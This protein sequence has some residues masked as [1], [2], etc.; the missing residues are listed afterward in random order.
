ML[1]KM[2]DAADLPICPSLGIRT[3]RSFLPYLPCTQGR[4]QPN[5]P[6]PAPFVH[7]TILGLKIQY[8]ATVLQS[9]GPRSATACTRAHAVLKLPTQCHLHVPSSLISTTSAPHHVSM[10]ATS[11]SPSSL[12]STTSAPHHLHDHSDSHRVISVFT[13]IKNLQTWAVH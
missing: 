10:Y 3:A 1:A 4:I 7:C 12:I 13:I 6:P 2:L 5:G 8:F 9:L 11:M